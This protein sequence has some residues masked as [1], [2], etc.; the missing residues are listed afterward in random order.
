VWQSWG[1][2]K[3][4]NFGNIADLSV[5]FIPVQVGADGGCRLIRVGGGFAWE[6]SLAF[7]TEINSIYINRLVFYRKFNYIEKFNGNIIIFVSI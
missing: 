3:S 6:G 1:R 2:V 5:T 4:G 7:T